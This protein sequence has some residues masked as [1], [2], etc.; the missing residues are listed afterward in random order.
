MFGMGLFHS[1]SRFE[2]HEERLQRRLQ[3]RQARG[4]AAAR[5]VTEFGPPMAVL[6]PKGMNMTGGPAADEALRKVSLPREILEC[7]LDSLCLV[8]LKLKLCWP[9]PSWVGT[10]L[11][12]Y[13]R[14]AAASFW[15][16]VCRI[17]CC[18]ACL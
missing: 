11:T 16:L 15:L 12:Q 5:K 10:T 3:R 14:R 18:C 6:V 2:R 9:G 4:V 8:Q 17:G 13:M 7:G 1:L